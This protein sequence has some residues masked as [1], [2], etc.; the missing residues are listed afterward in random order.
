MPLNHANAHWALAEIT[1]VSGVVDCVVYDSL[2][3]YL[4]HWQAMLD[5]LVLLPD[6]T[7]VN[8]VRRGRMPLQPDGTSCGVAACMAL[9][10]RLLRHEPADLWADGNV[11]RAERPFLFWEILHGRFWPR[12]VWASATA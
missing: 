12:A 10:A 4:K 11:Y 3:G 8:P 1:F 5:N 6:V 7:Q 9:R 2:P